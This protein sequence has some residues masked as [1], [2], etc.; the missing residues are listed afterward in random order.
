MN[1]ER[2]RVSKNII[3][4]DKWRSEAILDESIVNTLAMLSLIVN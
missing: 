2:E 3:L 4:T 1:R